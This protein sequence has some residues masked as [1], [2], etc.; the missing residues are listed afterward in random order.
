MLA[1]APTYHETPL[2]TA[3]L[4]IL[5]LNLM[6]FLVLSVKHKFPGRRVE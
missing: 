6:L 4:I 5:G 3:L 1:V 2:G